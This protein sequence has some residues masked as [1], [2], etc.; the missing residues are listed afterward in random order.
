MSHNVLHELEQQRISFTTSPP[1]T[2]K[3]L[4]VLLLSQL[5]DALVDNHSMRHYSDEPIAAS[6]EFFSQSF[7][8]SLMTKIYFSRQ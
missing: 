6:I 7:G 2:N 1:N 5:A 4:N 3:C 8:Q